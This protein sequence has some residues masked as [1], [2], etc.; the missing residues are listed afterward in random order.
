MLSI[1]TY[2]NLSPKPSGNHCPF[3]SV[4]WA[5]SGRQKRAKAVWFSAVALNIAAQVGFYPLHGALHISLGTQDQTVASYFCCVPPGPFTDVNTDVLSPLTKFNG[6][7]L[8]LLSPSGFCCTL[9]KLELHRGGK[10][11]SSPAPGSPCILQQCPFYMV[12]RSFSIA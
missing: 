1:S 8:P 10:E 9:D 12:Q 7:F 3:T 2:G 11:K 6:T 4:K 5:A